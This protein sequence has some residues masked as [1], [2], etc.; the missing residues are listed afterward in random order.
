M[1]H[2]VLC[3]ALI[4]SLAHAMGKAEKVAMGPEWP[5]TSNQ[6]TLTVPFT[7]TT[8]ESIL[9]ITYSMKCL[10]QPQG[11]EI[12]R[13]VT[14]QFTSGSRT[15]RMNLFE[16]ETLV[17]VSI[18]QATDPLLTIT[19]DPNPI[20]TLMNLKAVV[21]NND[22][23]I[24]SDNVTRTAIENAPYLGIRE[25]Q[26]TNRYTDLPM[27]MSYRV[28]PDAKHAENTD[29]DYI[30]YYSDEDSGRSA[31]AKSNDDGNYGRSGDIE[32]VYRIEFDPS[33]NPV[34][35][36]IQTS[37]HVGPISLGIGHGQ[38][39]FNGKFI[40]A[41]PIIYDATLNNVGADRPKD[42]SKPLTVYQM[43]PRMR[44]QLTDD[45]DDALLMSP[46]TYEVTDDEQSAEGKAPVPAQDHLF[47]M[48]E[49]ELNGIGPFGWATGK[50][51]AVITSSVGG[52]TNT[53][54]SEG[55]GVSRA[56][57][58]G[59]SWLRDSLMTAVSMPEA[60]VQ[61]L[62]DGKTHGSLT[63]KKESFERPDLNVKTIRFFR[64]LQDATGAMETRELTDHFYCDYDGVNSKCEFGI[65]GE[66]L[67]I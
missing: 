17:E 61:N 42:P 51:A 21:T 54:Q 46:W 44:L 20:C 4:P 13:G 34:S 41:H 33:W 9:Q 49:G 27:L 1:E 16:G 10:P 40:D 65:F 11:Q 24:G 37:L 22:F 47:V 30:I 48:I 7:P 36:I 26:Y 55:T 28:Y 8:T 57:I 38:E 62:E 14:G 50:F 3:L 66:Q 31:S 23:S 12:F 2:W 45:I 52:E 64:V 18:P 63:F 19:L 32:W 59:D 6:T 5:A 29:I 15:T 35:R 67:A 43:V 39:T 53:Y 60:D 56:A 25:D 58:E